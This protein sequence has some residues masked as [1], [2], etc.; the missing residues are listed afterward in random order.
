[1]TFGGTETGGD[2]PLHM[3]TFDQFTHCSHSQVP[4][5]GPKQRSHSLSA[6]IDR[7]QDLIARMKYTEEGLQNVKGNLRAH[8]IQ[9]LSSTLEQLLT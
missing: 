5:S 3:L 8:S 9:E 4:K 7:S 2:V 6:Y 1:M